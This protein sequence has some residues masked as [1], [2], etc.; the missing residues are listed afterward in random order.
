M[1]RLTRAGVGDERTLVAHHRPVEPSFECVRARRGK[2]AAGDDEDG[3]PCRPGRRDRDACALTEHAVLARS[4]CGR[5]RTRSRPRATG[6][7]AGG[8]EVALSAAQEPPAL[9]R[10]RAR[11]SATSVSLSEFA[12]MIPASKPSAITASGVTM[13]CR[14]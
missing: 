7:Q 6:T 5:D 2:H 4:A 14:T 13:P 8:S 12:G 10:S 1:Q 3:D 11:T 9:S